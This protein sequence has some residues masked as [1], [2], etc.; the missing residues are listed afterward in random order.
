MSGIAIRLSP[1]GLL[2]TAILVGS[3][4]LKDS[5]RS[6]LIIWLA[7]VYAACFVH[8][9][10][11]VDIGG[12]KVDYYEF[13]VV[14]FLIV[15]VAERIFK[16]PGSNA[17]VSASAG[18]LLFCVGLSILALLAIPSEIEIKPVD[19]GFSESFRLRSLLSE[20]SWTSNNVKSLIGLAMFLLFLVL[21]ADLVFLPET[22]SLLTRSLY[23]GVLITLGVFAIETGIN[24][25]SGG[26]LARVAIDTAFGVRASQIS[27][28]II[29]IFRSAYATYPEPSA[30]AMGMLAAVPFVMRSGR[31]SSVVVAA[32][33]VTLLLSVS[34][35]GLVVMCYIAWLYW[36]ERRR[37]RPLVF[38]ERLLVLTPILVAAFA[39]LVSLRPL[40]EYMIRNVGRIS[41]LLSAS[42]AGLGSELER[43]FHIRLNFKAWASRPLFGIG[44]GTTNAPGLIPTLL[45]NLGIV[46]SAALTWL[47][48]AWTRREPHEVAIHRMLPM[49]LLLTAAGQLSMIYSPILVIL[50]LGILKSKETQCVSPI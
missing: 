45:S 29:R 1:A 23:G 47:L 50:F 8:V 42:D 39:V 15:T 27:T 17:R 28:K 18:L 31:R 21:S 32:V 25:F 30:Y 22:R 48:F 40:V 7:T 34:L 12:F 35:T 10:F 44:L 16:L 24:T 19:A 37:S 41:V 5:I 6:R 9:G 26:S 4:F 43:F 38:L 11:V 2:F 46:G 13:G 3:L 20:P 36:I 14:F 33:C 49:L